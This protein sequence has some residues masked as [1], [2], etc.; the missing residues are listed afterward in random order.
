MCKQ[1][2]ACVRRQSKGKLEQSGTAERILVNASP[3]RLA[4]AQPA[5]ASRGGAG[6]RVGWKTGSGAIHS[7]PGVRG[8]G[9]GV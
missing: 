4:P 6:N 8:W 2:Q 1:R 5:Q 3:R 9:G 7:M